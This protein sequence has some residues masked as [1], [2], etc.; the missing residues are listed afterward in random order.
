MQCD[1]V[2]ALLCAVPSPEEAALLLRGPEGT[3]DGEL[4]A[5]ALLFKDAK[6]QLEVIDT[7]MSFPPAA[8]SIVQSCRD[9]R[10]FFHLLFVGCSLCF[11]A[12]KPTSSAAARAT[13]S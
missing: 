6:K 8:A 9:I 5:R 11:C 1:D 10:R 13:S 7:V 4:F 12:F 3:E 2:Q